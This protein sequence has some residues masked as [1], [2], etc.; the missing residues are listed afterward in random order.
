M[1]TKVDVFS[2]FL[3]AGKTYLIKKLI[4]DGCYPEK[5]V[6]IENEFGEVS[7]DGPL[8]GS[9]QVAVKEINAGCICCTVT[10]RFQEAIQ[11]VM[12]VYRP[13]Q[14]IIEPSG[15]AKLSEV[16]RALD[17]GNSGEALRLRVCAAVLD[18]VRVKEYLK[19]FSDFYSNQ[20]AHAQLLILS[21]TQLASSA[22][23]EE[24]AEIL[25]GINQ[26][27]PIIT[28]PWNTLSG[29]ALLAQTGTERDSF[30]TSKSLKTGRISKNTLASPAPIPR[31][32]FRKQK[33][34]DQVFDVWTAVPSRPYTHQGLR[35][36]FN[37]LERDGSYGVIARGKGILPVQGGGW[38]VFQY[39]PG[40]LTMETVSGQKTGLLSIIGRVL[41]KGALKELFETEAGR[42]SP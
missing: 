2:G 7:I 28:Q 38:M 27:A 40:E 5:T 8:L 23:I 29:S 26:N 24:V 12:A 33:R 16:I 1:K 34:A 11:E 20:I 17:L 3:G 39:V 13:E 22:L 18:V 41:D 6:I 10:G 37:I 19:N 15:V 32:S 14:L 42:E 30:A 4:E 21:R 9:T 36:I 35:K 25:G 31:A